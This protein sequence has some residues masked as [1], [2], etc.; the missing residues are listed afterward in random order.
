M[1]S[2]NASKM[3]TAIVGDYYFDLVTG[4]NANITTVHLDET[5]KYQWPELTDVKVQ[6]LREILH[7]LHTIT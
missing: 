7:L 4:R 1:Q 2:W 6:S 3:E 5:S